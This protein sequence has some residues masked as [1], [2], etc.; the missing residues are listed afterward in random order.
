MGTIDTLTK[1]HEELNKSTTSGHLENLTSIKDYLLS[2]YLYSQFQV[3]MHMNDSFPYILAYRVFFS[4]QKNGID[5]FSKDQISKYPVLTL[6]SSLQTCALLTMSRFSNMHAASSQGIANGVTLILRTGHGFILNALNLTTLAPTLQMYDYALPSLGISGIR[7]AMKWFEQNIV[8]GTHDPRI[9]GL[10][11]PQGFASTIGLRVKKTIHL[12]HP[13]TNCTM[14]DLEE[15]LLKEQ[16]HEVFRFETSQ[17]STIHYT[18]VNCR[19][20]KY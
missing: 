13:Y 16:I 20:Q 17:S 4:C 6:E 7:L 18:A 1:L 2:R 19:Y 10:D 15:E 3:Q 8:D 9:E 12:A 5:F 11:V 14:I